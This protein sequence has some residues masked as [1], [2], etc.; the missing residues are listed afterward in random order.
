MPQGGAPPPSEVLGTRRGAQAQGSTSSGARGELTTERALE[1][2]FDIIGRSDGTTQVPRDPVYVPERQ[3]Q[4]YTSPTSPPEMST[5]GALAALAAIINKAPTPQPTGHDTYSVSSHEWEDTLMVD[6]D[7]A[8]PGI[9]PS[10]GGFSSINPIFCLYW[11]T[12]P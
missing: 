4:A 10:R 9:P 11:P 6:A 5:A 1:A 8:P 7:E 2:L 12:H 3:A